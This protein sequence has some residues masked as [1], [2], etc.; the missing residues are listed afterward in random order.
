MADAIRVALVKPVKAQG[1]EISELT[2][3]EPTGM[4]I[5]E[6]GGPPVLLD[7]TSDPPAVTFDGKKMTAMLA[8]L[9]AVPPSTIKALSAEDWTTAAWSVSPFFIPKLGNPPPAPATT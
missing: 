7:M 6:V 9:A 8:R 3:R 5:A 4:D 2:L 1:E